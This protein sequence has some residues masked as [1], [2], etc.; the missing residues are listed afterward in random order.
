MKTTEYIKCKIT[1]YQNPSSGIQRQD[2]TYIPKP[3]IPDKVKYTPRQFNFSQDNRSQWQ[4]EQDKQK[5]D[6]NYNKYIENKNTQQGLE[7]LNGFL[8]FTDYV[9]L[10]TGVGALLGKGV[11]YVGKQAVRNAANNSSKKIIPSYNWAENWMDKQGL[12]SYAKPN[13]QGDALALTKDRMKSGGFDRLSTLTTDKYY[14]KV[15]QE[16]YNNFEE[17]MREFLLK[18]QPKKGKASDF[19]SKPINV[20]A[21]DQYN[22]FYTEIFDDAPEAFKSP[23]PNN[24]LTAHE[25][26]HLLY[27]PDWNNKVALNIYNPPHNKNYLLSP[28]DGGLAEQ[29][30]RGTQLKNYFG[31]KEG[32]EITPEM[33]NYAKKYYTKDM[34]FDNNMTEWFEGV[35]NVPEYLK[36]LNKNAPAVAAP[37]IGA[38]M[39]NDNDKTNK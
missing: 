6:E 17:G 21:S 32:E 24:H 7:N 38:K 34:R 28:K 26:S 13:W 37:V 22:K 20:G 30:A 1:K 31:L 5:A 2:N 25:Y 19:N 10:G 33:W 35:K 27:Q 9:G 39:I 15:P 16:N 3:K 18:A 12:P 11:K 4:Q 14:N 36:W 29:T 8:N 23:R